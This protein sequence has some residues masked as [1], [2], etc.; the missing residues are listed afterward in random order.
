RRLA[1]HPAT[2]IGFV[3][4]CVA[5]WA[6]NTGSAPVLNRAGA[7]TSL[8]LALV[9]AGGMIAA[10][11]AAVRMWKTERSEALDVTPAS[12]RARTLGLLMASLGPLALALGLQAVALIGMSLDRPVTVLDWWD[13]LAGP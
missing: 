7:T 12:E 13:V 1:I 3:L 4:A 8:P 5:L 6:L 2:L 9:A 11:D 10:A